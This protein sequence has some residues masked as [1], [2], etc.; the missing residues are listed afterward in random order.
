MK[1]LITTIAAIILVGC[2][3]SHDNITKEN[4]YSSHSGTYTLK[5]TKLQNGSVTF[6][7]YSDG[8]LIG[9][10]ANVEGD[11]NKMIGSW[12]IDGDLLVCE[13]TVKKGYDGL[14]VK[15]NKN[16]GKVVSIRNGAEA[17][18]LGEDDLYFTKKE[19]LTKCKTC[20]GKISKE[21]KVCPHCGQ[22]DPV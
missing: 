10:I 15:F 7:L 14:I 11:E 17:K 12:K 6:D 8:S 13:E 2:G 3:S 9:A 1:N 5:P 16:T 4:Q 22:P 20:Q 18:E 21:A 19:L